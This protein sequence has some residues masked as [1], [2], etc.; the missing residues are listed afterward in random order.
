MKTDISQT[1]TNL[2]NKIQ[3][4]N[5]DLQAALR[6]HFDQ[7]QDWL[8]LKARYYLELAQINAHWSDDQQVTIALLQ[9]ADALLRTIPDQQLFTV[10][11]AIAQEITQ[12]QVLPKWTSLA[13]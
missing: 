11:Q 12:L 9:Q 3:Q 5:K 1:Q 8:L 2:Q 7:K 4:M 6:E 10:R 13:S